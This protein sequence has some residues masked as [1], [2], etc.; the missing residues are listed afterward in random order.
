MATP[1]NHFLIATHLDPTQQ[2]VYLSVVFYE[3]SNP[4]HAKPDF[5]LAQI[6]FLTDSA[7]YYC[8]LFKKDLVS[9]LNWSMGLLQRLKSMFGEDTSSLILN[10]NAA[11]QLLTFSAENE[12]RAMR[13]VLFQK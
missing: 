11:S 10:F 1:P 6:H 13:F 5:L 8:E 4:E 2:T 9:D 12:L 7:S 3:P